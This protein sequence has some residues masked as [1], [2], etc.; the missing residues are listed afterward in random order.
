M[1]LKQGP[2]LEVK[3]CEKCIVLPIQYMFGAFCVNTSTSSI[4]MS[5]IIYEIHV[6]STK[7]SYSNQALG[8]FQQKVKNS[9][10]FI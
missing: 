4:N 10:C 3:L 2:G 1:L 8:W 5:S 9:F 7:L 6:E